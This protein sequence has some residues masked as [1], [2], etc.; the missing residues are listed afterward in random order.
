MVTGWAWSLAALIAIRFLFGIAEGPYPAAALK[1]MSETYEKSEKSQAT[2]ALISSNY[3]G[4][5]VAPLII[6]PIFAS[7]VSRNDFV[8]LGVGGFII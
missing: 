7:S 5:A 8:W 6:V 3:A 1:R 2:T 4:A